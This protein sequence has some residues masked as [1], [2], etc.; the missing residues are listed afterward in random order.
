MPEGTGRSPTV[1]EPGAAWGLPR[2]RVEDLGEIAKHGVGEPCIEQVLEELLRET[3]RCHRGSASSRSPSDI[4][5]MEAS[6]RRST[7]RPLAVTR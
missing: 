3:G 6:D 7:R 4:R 2:L 5:R 1:A